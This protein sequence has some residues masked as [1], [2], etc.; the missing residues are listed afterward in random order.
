MSNKSDHDLLIEIATDIK[1]IK[2]GI[3]VN[4]KKIRTKPPKTVALWLQKDH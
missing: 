3:L 2:K 4:Q 1:Y